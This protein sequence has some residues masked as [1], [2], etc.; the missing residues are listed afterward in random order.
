[1]NDHYV[2]YRVKLCMN[3][4]PIFF[5]TTCNIWTFIVTRQS[6][7]A[8]HLVNYF[9][10]VIYLDFAV[11]FE[12]KCNNGSK[13]STVPSLEKLCSIFSSYLKLTKYTFLRKKICLA[14]T[15]S[16]DCKSSVSLKSA[17]TRKMDHRKTVTRMFPF[18]VPLPWYHI[19]HFAFR[20]LELKTLVCP[21]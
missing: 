20:T 14:F 3:G 11:Y 21:F 9:Q 4:F 8:R 18:S 2:H 16:K 1:M 7:Q 15:E 5:E 17:P 6:L 19:H 10:T 13:S 12:Q